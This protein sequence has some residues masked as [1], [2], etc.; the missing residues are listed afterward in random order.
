VFWLAAML[1]RERS[2]ARQ[3]LVAVAVAGTAYAGYGLLVHFA[4]WE[5]ILW[6]EKWAYPGD[7]TATFVNRNAYGA[8]AGLGLLACMGLFFHAL[9]PARP[10]AARRAHDVAE[11]VLV[12]ALPFL[13]AAVLI[14]SALLLSHSRGA[15]ASAG[16][17]MVVLLAAV[18][19]GRVL[20]LRTA[21][22]LGVVL[23]GIGLAVLSVSGDG[24][25]DRL[26]RTSLANADEQRAEVYALTTRA[27]LDAP[28]TGHGFGAF[29]PA[30]RIY[31]STALS[32]PLVWDFAHNVALESAMDLGIP[33][34][35]AL[36]GA[37]TAVVLA[38]LRGLVVRRRDHI[39]PAVAVAAAVLVGGHGLVDFSAQMPAVAVTL[40]LLLGIGFAQSRRSG[41]E[42]AGA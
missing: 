3:A 6:L 40:A 41:E 34:A 14:G 37:V 15:F 36:Y 10:G 38:C 23:A 21:L 11:M 12:R 4:G 35:L 7:L 2:R 30:F 25:V 26:A 8:Y 29:L 17:G 9:R 33:A 39:Y 18:V 28:L 1:G 19:V 5:R 31:R 32:T 24:T 22:L 13:A 27:V 16:A 20:R 42:A